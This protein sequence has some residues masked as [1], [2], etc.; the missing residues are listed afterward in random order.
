MAKHNV[1]IFESKKTKKRFI[2]YT[3]KSL[4]ERLK[5]LNRARKGVTKNLL[6]GRPFKL[7]YN[8]SY[9]TEKEALERVVLLKHEA[10]MAPDLFDRRIADRRKSNLPTHF[11]NRRK[12]ERRSLK[13]RRGGKEYFSF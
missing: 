1:C 7:V 5:E 6:K 12:A 8:E 4:A 10:K 13:E 3:D 2:E 9:A 11:P